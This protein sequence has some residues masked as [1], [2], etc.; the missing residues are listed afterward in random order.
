MVEYDG[1]DIARCEQVLLEIKH[2]FLDDLV[3][4]QSVSVGKFVVALRID[5]I[6]GLLNEVVTQNFELSHKADSME[7]ELDE[8]YQLDTPEL[9]E[10]SKEEI[11]ELRAVIA[12]WDEKRCKVN[13][14]S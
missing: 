14:Q 1:R 6:I 9:E 13:E 12:E 11:L 7:K 5:K 4:P 10:L 2:A 8:F 3:P